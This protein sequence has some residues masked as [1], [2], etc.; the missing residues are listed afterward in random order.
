M[1]SRSVC[2][3]FNSGLALDLAWVS[4]YSTS[5]MCPY[6]V[7]WCNYGQYLSVVLR[8]FFSTI[9]YSITHSTTY[10]KQILDIFFTTFIWQL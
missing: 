4:L 1:L 8:Y 7:M 6:L 3:K 2:C 10:Q 9:L 5:H